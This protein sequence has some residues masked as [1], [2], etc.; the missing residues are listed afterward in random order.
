MNKE[1][2]ESYCRKVCEWLYIDPD[3]EIKDAT[4][5]KQIPRWEVLSYILHATLKNN[6]L[7]INEAKNEI[8]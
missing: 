1:E 5:K 3:E 4:S 7:F 8:H 2:W 6:H